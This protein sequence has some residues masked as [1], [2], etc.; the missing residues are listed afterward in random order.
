MQHGFWPSKWLKAADARLIV[1]ELMVSPPQWRCRT[2][3]SIL[4]SAK[5]SA[6]SR[7]HLMAVSDWFRGRT[8]LQTALERGL[9]EGGQLAQEID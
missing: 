7:D 9:K 5:V 6:Q 8:P 2:P 1:G 3:F 4:D